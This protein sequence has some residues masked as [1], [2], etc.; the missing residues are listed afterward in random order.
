MSLS[1]ACGVHQLTAAAT[2]LGAKLGDAEALAV[3]ALTAART[4][5]SISQPRTPPAAYPGIRCVR[6]FSFPAHILDDTGDSDGEIT[7]PPHAALVNFPN[8]NF[9]AH[10]ERARSASIAS[11]R[12]VG[13]P[14]Q[15]C[16]QR[17]VM[18]GL[19]AGVNADGNEVVI[20]MQN[21]HVCTDCDSGM[22]W[23]KANDSY[24]KWCK[25]C[26]RFRMMAA[27]RDKIRG[28]RGAGRTMTLPT[29]CDGCRD[30][31][32]A[33]YQAKKALTGSGRNQAAPDM[34]V[35]P[36]SQAHAVAVKAQ[37][38]TARDS[39][40]VVGG[41]GGGG[42]AGALDALLLACLQQ[43]AFGEQGQQQ[44]Q[45]QQQQLEEKDD[46]GEEDCP[47]EAEEEQHRQLEKIQ[48]QK[49]LQQQR[50]RR[51][52]QKQQQQRQKE[53]EQQTQQQIQLQQYQQQAARHH[54]AQQKFYHQHH[55]YQQ[56]HY[57]NFQ[58]QYQLQFHGTA[59]FRASGAAAGARD[60]FGWLGPVAFG[61]YYP[62]PVR[63]TPSVS[64]VAGPSAAAA[65]QALV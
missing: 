50:Q 51:R 27:F 2:A 19:E 17:C 4:A 16:E 46:E 1:E 5:A 35:T 3:E 40:V 8:T 49:E 15:G 25:G 55:E 59:A 60:G 20:P 31:G 18:C 13:R 11:S 30:R 39:V 23:F 43:Q 10:K 56:Q 14:P 28:L 36:L 48:E 6:V 47:D 21:K 12:K 62:A 42:S 33:G 64:S 26:K 41:G 7:E 54:A 65:P 38:V 29:K 34:T 44:Q 61:G 52:Q 22:W 63:A 9:A 24:V 58:H 57:L 37:K 32:R 53:Q 45:Q